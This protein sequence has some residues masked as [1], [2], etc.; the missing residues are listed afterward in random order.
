MLPHGKARAFG[1]GANMGHWRWIKEELTDQGL[2]P[3]LEA[4]PL[5]GTVAGFLTWFCLPDVAGWIKPR[6]IQTASGDYILHGAF[7]KELPA[8]IDLVEGEA[9]FVGS[10]ETATEKGARRLSYVYVIGK[11]RDTILIRIGFY[12]D[13]ARPLVYE[14]AK[15]IDRFI[16]PND[17][18]EPFALDDR[19]TEDADIDM[20]IEDLQLR[21]PNKSQTISPLEPTNKITDAD[22]ERA[23]REGVPKGMTD[24][25]IGRSLYLSRTV[26]TKHRN[27][28]GIKPAFE[29]GRGPNRRRAS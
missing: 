21:P 12:F 2:T 13:Y 19:Q 27:A 11:S 15:M 16:S 14:I 10:Y 4:G 7:C 8:T 1:L 26:I 20:Q 22:I 24:A 29:R 9:V 5:E 6:R 3:E 17:V 28:L 23:I 18:S 25:Q